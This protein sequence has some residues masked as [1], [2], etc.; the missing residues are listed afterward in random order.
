[1][2]ENESGGPPTQGQLTQWAGQYGLST[3]VLSDAGWS[4]FDAFWNQNYTPANMLIA[5]GMQVVQTDWVSSSDI[6]SVLP[7]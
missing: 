1:M 3:P 4:T 5:P 7:L 6:E 2:A